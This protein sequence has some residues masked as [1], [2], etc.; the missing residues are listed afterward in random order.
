MCFGLVWSSSLIVCR[1]V[2]ENNLKVGLC[3]L[4]SEP[5]SL[6]P[7]LAGGEND[8]D[9]GTMDRNW[10]NWN[11]NAISRGRASRII[12]YAIKEERMADMSNLQKGSVFFCF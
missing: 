10:N 6:V 1:Q 7:Y 2:R 4:H 11:G 12:D 5:P 8:D 3:V 9:N